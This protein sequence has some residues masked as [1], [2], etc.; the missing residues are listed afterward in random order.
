MRRLSSLPV[1]VGESSDFI[2]RYIR[3]LQR[4][5]RPDNILFPC[6]GCESDRPGTR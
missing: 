5:R 6:P 2:V 4:G 1:G 3:I